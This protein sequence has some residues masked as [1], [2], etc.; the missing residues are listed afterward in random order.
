MHRRQALRLLA[1]AAALPLLSRE[2]F[3]M[4]QAVHDQLPEHA[5]LKTLNPHQDAHRHNHQRDHHSAN[6]YSGSQSC[7]SERIHR[8]DSYRLV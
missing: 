2:A 7:S 8:P 3:S 5:V 6:Q 1:S 4:F